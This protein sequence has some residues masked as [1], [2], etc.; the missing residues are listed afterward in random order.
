MK[1]SLLIAAAAAMALLVM[2]ATRAQQPINAPPPGAKGGDPAFAKGKGGGKGK[3]APPAGPTPRRAD[4]KVILGGETP[5]KNG[6]WLPGGDITLPAANP[7]ERRVPRS[8]DGLQRLFDAA[9]GSERACFSRD[10]RGGVH[11][12]C[13]T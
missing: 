2:D 13:R 12:A 7:A 6:V 8:R 1:K 4:G 3:A 10:R 5:G 11:L 9:R